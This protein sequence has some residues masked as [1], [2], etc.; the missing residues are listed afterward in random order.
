MIDK[1]KLLIKV[2]DQ[3]NQVL[4]KSFDDLIIKKLDRMITGKIDAFIMD[5]TVKFLDKELSSIIRT[6]VM[7]NKDDILERATEAIEGIILREIKYISETLKRGHRMS[8]GH[9]TR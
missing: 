8:Y 7:E 6:K 2:Q 4:E 9:K 3:F 5:M 1:E